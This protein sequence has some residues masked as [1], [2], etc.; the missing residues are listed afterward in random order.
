M[1][2]L[3]CGGVIAICLAH[4]GL[5][6]KKYYKARAKL[7]EDCLKF[8]ELLCDEIAYAKP[9]LDKIIDEFLAG[10]RSEFTNI[11]KKFRQGMSEGKSAQDTKITSK[12][13]SQSEKE[14]IT[15]FL[16]NLGRF[17]AQT[18]LNN[19]AGYKAKIAKLKTAAEEKSNTNGTM[20]FKL[21]MLLGIVV[22]IVLA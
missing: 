21:M 4:V 3:V 19:L 16:Q 13:L 17:D 12:Y 7:Y 11:L 1:L 15:E 22:L 14:L 6:I 8:V 9:T 2:K 18:Q 5:G 20:A 10:N